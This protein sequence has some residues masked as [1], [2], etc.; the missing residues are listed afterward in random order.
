MSVTDFLRELKQLPQWVAY[1]LVWNERKGKSDKMPINPHDGAGAKANDAATWGTYDEAMQFATRKGLFASKAGGIGFEFANGYAGIDLD[2]VVLADGSLKPYAEEIVCTMNSYTEYSP[3]GHGLH[4]L[5][6]LSKPLSDMGSRKKN[7]ELGLEVYDTGRFFTITGQVYGEGRPIID[8]TSALEK[9]YVKYWSMVVKEK[10]KEAPLLSSVGTEKFNWRYQ[11]EPDTL[12]K[13]FNSEHGREIEALYYGDISDYPSQSEADMALCCH[14]AYWTNNDASRMDS[15]FRASRLFRPKWDEVHY[16]G[17]ETYG[18][19]TINEAIRRT[20]TYIP[21]SESGRRSDNGGYEGSR[22]E[23]SEAFFS[24]SSRNLL[25]YFEDRFEDNLARF[26]LYKNRKTGFSNIDKYTSLYPGLYAIGAV[27]SIGKTTFAGQMADNLAQAGDYVLFF[28]LE[29]TELE[30]AT[31]GLSRLSAIE[32]F[33]SAVSS[34][35]IRKGKLTDAVMRAIGTYKVFAEHITIIECGFDTTITVITETVRRYIQETGHKP[36]VFIDYL[37]LICPAN[38]KLTGKDAV[39]SNVRALKLLQRENDLVLFVISSFNRQ[40]YLSV[41]EFESFKESGIIEYSC[42]VVWALQLLAMNC[43]L[44]DTD[45]KLQTK[46]KFVHEAR[47]AEPRK[48][49]LVGLKNRYGRSFTRYFFNYYAKYDLFL[50]YDVTEEQ[51]DAEIQEAFKE[52]DAKQ[53]ND[54]DSP[55]TKRKRI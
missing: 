2:N 53:G 20:P 33:S 50:P 41:A 23:S 27:S 42:D 11:P 25:R 35:D 36:V 10:A 45:K 40:N 1:R 14:L 39:D 52:F 16:G 47:N 31:K 48:I 12:E 46:R 15:L 6:K 28:S 51:A 38:N 30:I 3:S 37:Q 18:Q 24:S 4:I 29:Q 54:D 17:T 22:E 8:G 55:K 34:I 19:H 21:H 9:I 32:N 49:E 43:A 44:F 13:M 26:A 7:P 5:F